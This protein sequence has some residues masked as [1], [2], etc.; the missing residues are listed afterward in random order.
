MLEGLRRV[1]VR[2]QLRQEFDSGVSVELTPDRLGV[3]DVASLLKEYLRDLPDPLLTRELFQAFLA[4][5]GTLLAR[6]TV[7]RFSA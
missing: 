2:R 7:F 6:Q 4:T 5:A 1:A 3:H